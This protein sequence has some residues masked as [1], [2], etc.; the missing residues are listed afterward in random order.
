MIH[1]KKTQIIKFFLAMISIIIFCINSYS[2][3]WANGTGNA[4][5]TGDDNQGI[6][7]ISCVAGNS[8]DYYIA[9][10]AEYFL[11]SYANVLVFM[12]KIEM[13]F[14]RELN[15]RDLSKLIDLTLIKVE[16]AWYNYILLKETADKT[17]YNQVVI[18]TL[19]NFDYE[20]FMQTNS[21]NREI[22]LEVKE[23]LSNG[24]VSE[25]YG[26]LTCDIEAIYNLL[27][28][29]KLS[30]DKNRFPPVKT[31]RKLNQVYS[32]SLLF[33]QYT[34]CVFDSL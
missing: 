27:Q 11:D 8:L 1:A 19:K 12:G 31:V 33:G 25:I 4:Y 28:A 9:K 2:W 5:Y 26:K 16:Q 6:S 10:A 32:E 22:F 15:Y 34:S 7:G 13:S 14:Y 20:Q 29:V 17:P 30:I 24:R 23:Y 18:E 21:L 3:W